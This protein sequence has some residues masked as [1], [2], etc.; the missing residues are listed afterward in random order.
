M[1]DMDEDL[2]WFAERSHWVIRKVPMTKD[3]WYVACG[4]P[5]YE[6]LSIYGIK[7]V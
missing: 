7:Y 5:P 6:V 1:G 2:K 3:E 4:Y